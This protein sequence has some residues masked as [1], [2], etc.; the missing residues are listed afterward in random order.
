[1]TAP[2]DRPDE[3]PA[4]DPP[5]GGGGL[6]GTSVD[7][8]NRRRDLYLLERAAVG[9][10]ALPTAVYLN[11]PAAMAEVLKDGN[12]RA[13]IAAAKVLLALHGQNLAADA[14]SD[15]LH[16]MAGGGWEDDAPE[17]PGRVAVYLPDNGRGADPPPIDPCG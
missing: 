12:D 13:K 9:R 7:P 6:G 14:A 10:W 8:V 15:T 17:P 16:A 2:T 3:S 4:P 1:M 11:V 5:D